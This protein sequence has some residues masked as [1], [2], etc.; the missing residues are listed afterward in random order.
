MTN[1]ALAARRRA[2][3]Y[4]GPRRPFKARNRCL[5]APREPATGADSLNCPHPGPKPAA[6]RVI[7]RPAALSPHESAGVELMWRQIVPVGDI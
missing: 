6:G 1:Q 2:G 7:R 5:G 3:E 4:H